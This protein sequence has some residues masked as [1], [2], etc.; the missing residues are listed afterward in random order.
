MA[1]S[2]ILKKLY[3]FLLNQNIITLSAK[4]KI[5]ADTVM[6]GVNIRGNVTVGEKS[7]LKFVEII[8]KVKIGNHTTINGPNVQILSKVNTIEIGSFCSIAKDVT[9]QEYNH[10]VDRLS[11]YNFE[12]HIFSGKSIDDVISKGAITIGSDV[13]IGTKS[14]I[15]SGVTIGHGAIVAAGSVVTKD[16]PPYAIVG[17]NPARVIKYRFTA[18]IIERLLQIEWWRWPIEKIK[19]NKGFFL[20]NVNVRNLTL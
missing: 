1:L 12:K 20:D 6:K 7:I 16:V 13:W 5:A 9:I 11:T 18:E 15:L 2:S 17:G 14:V 10:R 4:G 3:N 8:G 19:V